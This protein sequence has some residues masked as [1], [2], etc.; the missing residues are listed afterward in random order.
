MDDPARSDREPREHT[1]EGPPSP[2][3]VDPDAGDASRPEVK[4]DAKLVGELEKLANPR[5]SWTRNI[6]MLVVSVV[7]FYTLGIFEQPVP[8][9]LI[10]LGAIF[11]H[12][13]GHLVAMKLFDYQN[14]QMF[15]IPLLGAAVSG[16]N[17]EAAG[18]KRAVVTLMGPVT[19]LAL[20]FGLSVWWLRTG[21]RLLGQAALT[22]AALNLFNLL[23]FYPLDGGRFLQEVLFARNRFLGAVFR[24]IL[25]GLTVLVAVAMEAWFLAIIGG[26]VLLATGGS[27]K[28]SS[29][30]RRL[31]G[32]PGFPESVVPKEASAEVIAATRSEIKKSFRQAVP[33]AMEA[34]RI[35]DVWEKVNARPPRALAAFAL[36]LAYF[37][38]LMAVPVV[39]IS[40]SIF[41]VNQEIVE[42][43]RPDGS[44]GRMWQV[45]I[46]RMVMSETELNEDDL[47]HGRQVSYSL[48][49]A[50]KKN[51][52]GSWHE[53]FPDGEWRRLNAEG[54]PTVVTVFER[55]R[56]VVRREYTPTGIVEKKLSDLSDWE[57]SMLLKYMRKG[58][59]GPG[60]KAGN[61]P[62]H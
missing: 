47:Y 55:G 33:P 40:F 57:R 45:R 20:A 27:F 39:L 36:L 1:P 24:V 53:G 16:Q 38:S 61:L 7:L 3:A 19:G 59:Y 42:Y 43:N 30:A 32:T 56:F 49:F 17:A 2:D 4:L 9:T 46:G 10:L 21:E 48:G 26:L 28:I 5:T 23:P 11:I 15:F 12:E 50:K 52:E 35:W 13:M 18:W 25:C 51:R 58:P 34:R 6:G 60:K 37:L 22:F 62:V 54:K 29:V 8:D 41:G 31:K 14:V 44:T